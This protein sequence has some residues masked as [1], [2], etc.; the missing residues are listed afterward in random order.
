MILR[1][2]SESNRTERG[3]ATQAILMSVY[4]T[5]RLRGHNPTETIANTLRAYL[6]TGQ[7]P[8]LPSAKQAGWNPPLASPRVIRVGLRLSE[9]DGKMAHFMGRRIRR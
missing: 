5:L 6:T 2:N 9:C 7:L 3:A 4:R 8:P 1:K